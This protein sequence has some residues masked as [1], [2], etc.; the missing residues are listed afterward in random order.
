MENQ[1]RRIKS[2]VR[3]EG[4]DS[5][6]RK[7]L[8]EQ[9]WPV[10]GIDADRGLLDLDNLFGRHA[11]NFL[12]IGFGTGTA[13]LDMAMHNPQNN[14]LGVEV[15]E[16]GISQV[17]KQAGESGLDNIRLFNGDAVDILQKHIP[18]NS[19]DGVYL[20]FPDPWHKK[21]HHKRRLVQT[22][23][24]QLVIEKLKR[25]GQFHAATDWEDYA[26]HMMWVLGSMQQLHN[27]AGTGEFSARPDY[28]PLTKFERRGHRL[29]HGVWDLLFTKT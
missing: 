12:E 23:F 4:R 24:M 18:A 6:K 19:L 17:M 21:R 28:R 27:A 8:F 20:F 29:G 15:Y 14:Y 5:A 26:Q 10:Y 1:A 11:P 3:R 13:L 2:F 16:T 25:G 7:H 9:Y 22:G